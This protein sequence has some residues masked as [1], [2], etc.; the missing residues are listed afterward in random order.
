MGVPTLFTVGVLHS[1]V[2]PLALNRE[3]TLGNPG[4]ALSLT[5]KGLYFERLTGGKKT[6]PSCLRC[7]K[8]PK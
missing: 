6:H 3:G 7:L 8:I 2:Q 1:G 4:R 5:S